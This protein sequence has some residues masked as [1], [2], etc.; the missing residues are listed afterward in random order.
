M[1]EI[2]VARSS[3]GACRACGPSASDDAARV[4]SVIDHLI[5][6]GPEVE[7][8]VW[9][10]GLIRLAGSSNCLGAQRNLIRDSSKN[11]GNK[12]VRPERW[13]CDD[14]LLSQGLVSLGA[15]SEHHM[16]MNCEAVPGLSIQVFA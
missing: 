16:S 9:C 5:D 13:T 10:M 4:P 8:Q 7:H 12:L 3:A 1:G 15:V 14:C 11:P 6:G 2:A